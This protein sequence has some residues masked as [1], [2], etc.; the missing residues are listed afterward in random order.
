M[1]NSNSSPTLNNVTFSANSA[2]NFG[3]G[4]FNTSSSSP[5]LTNVTFSANSATNY[6]GGMFNTSSSSP[7]LTN[8]TFSN[9]TASTHGGGMTNES[10]SNPTLTNAIVWGNTNDQIYNSSSTP[11]IT[12]SDVQGCGGSDAWDTTCGTD[13]GGNIDSDP[14]LGPL[15]DNGG[16]TL[17]RAL[18]NDSPAIDA[19]DPNNCPSSDQRGFYRPIDGNKDGT[20]R[21]DMG[22]YEFGSISLYLPL[23]FR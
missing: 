8:V 12:Y 4:M 6:G 2:T 14:L 23:I 10:S 19:G 11:I 17:T 5:T 15:A 18:G 9:N 7:T 16:F 22:A 1:Y 13:L 21:C 3:G 20:A